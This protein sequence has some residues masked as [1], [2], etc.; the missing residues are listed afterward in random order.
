[1][2]YFLTYTYVP[3]DVYNTQG[4]SK[5]YLRTFVSGKIID[6]VMELMHEGFKEKSRKQKGENDI[7]SWE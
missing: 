1:M 5:L 2:I 6:I 4:F 3:L 7:F